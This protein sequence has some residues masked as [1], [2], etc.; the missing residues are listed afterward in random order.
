M[1]KFLLA[2]VDGQHAG[3]DDL[4]RCRTELSRLHSL[5]ISHE[6]LNRQHFLVSFTQQITKRRVI[7]CHQNLVLLRK[8][9][10]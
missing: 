6:D 5:E 7:L 1:N 2:K 10:S 9:I 8:G 3:I 4:H